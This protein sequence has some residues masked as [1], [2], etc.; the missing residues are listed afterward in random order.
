MTTSTGKL[1]NALWLLTDT[2]HETL[3][4]APMAEVVEAV[5]RAYLALK[6]DIRLADHWEDERTD[7]EVRIAVLRGKLRYMPESLAMVEQI[8]ANYHASRAK[9]NKLTYFTRTFPMVHPAGEI[10]LPSKQLI[11]N[12]Q[13]GGKRLYTI[14]TPITQYQYTPLSGYPR[15]GFMTRF[16]PES[17]HAYFEKTL[18]KSLDVRLGESVMWGGGYTHAGNANTSDTLSA[19]LVIRLTEEPI[20]YEPCRRISDGITET[21]KNAHDGDMS[22][23]EQIEFCR[24][25][26]DA[27]ASV[28]ADQ[29]FEDVLKNAQAFLR[30]RIN[31]PSNEL[32]FSLSVLAQRLAKQVN[33][34]FLYAAALL[35]GGEYLYGIQYF[36]TKYPD[37]SSA[38]IRTLL[39]QYDAQRILPL[40]SYQMARLLNETP[41]DDAQP[42]YF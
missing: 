31:A 37:L 10:P 38:D 28:S 24:A 4:S 33:Q 26:L 14:W 17:T 20:I 2:K 18:K 16:F 42:F 35:A 25:A 6:S 7:M 36:R 32:G 41:P 23:Q 11:H 30:S 19:A 27:A 22:A 34:S 5:N 29:P 21:D 39:A 13:V 1:R 40:E 9:N 8:L 15:Y 12:D 3:T